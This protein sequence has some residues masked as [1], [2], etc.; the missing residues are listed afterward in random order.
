L[1]TCGHLRSR[2]LIEPLD[3]QCAIAGFDGGA[4]VNPDLSVIES[5]TLDP[6]TAKQTVK[7]MLGQGLDVWVYTDNEWLIRNR[8]AHMWR[9]RRTR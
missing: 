7:L 5:H 6:P 3:L 8:D 1:K 4:F 2:R 9:A